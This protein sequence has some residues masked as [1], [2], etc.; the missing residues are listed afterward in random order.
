MERIHGP[1]LE[2]ILQR[3]RAEKRPLSPQDITL[4]AREVAQGLLYLHQQHVLHRD[5]KSGNILIGDHHGVAHARSGGSGFG[6]VAALS[7]SEP[8]ADEASALDPGDRKSNGGSGSKAAKKGDSAA[9][10][11]VAR[12]T[13]KVKRTSAGKS[14]KKASASASSALKSEFA[15][16][17]VKICD[18]N[19]SVPLE[20]AG[21][22][23]KLDCVGTER[24][25]A[26]EVCFKAF[27]MGRTDILCAVRRCFEL[28]SVRTRSPSRARR[29]TSGVLLCNVRTSFLMRAS[30]FSAGRSA[31]CCSRC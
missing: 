20:G 21:E 1:S 17:D 29:R 27:K 11:A 28:A 19:Q 5:L 23:K 24:W 2:S 15:G 10:P 30:D 7:D 16:A 13:S 18:F 31:W 12:A 25:M 3:R 6:D 14:A 9:K 22:R 4:L 26:P 8:S